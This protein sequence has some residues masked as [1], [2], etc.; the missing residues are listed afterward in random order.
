[1]TPNF[2]RNFH[3]LG[4]FREN[5]REIWGVLVVVLIYGSTVTSIYVEILPHF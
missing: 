3:F 2:Y 1:M 4:Y 5:F